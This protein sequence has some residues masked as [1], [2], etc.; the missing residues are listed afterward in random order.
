MLSPNSGIG[1]Y[2]ELETSLKKNIWHKKS[3]Y[4][5]S[6]RS[7]LVALLRSM[8]DVNLVWMPSYI[9]NS[10]FNAV[11]FAE[12]KIR[13]YHINESF[14]IIEKINLKKD[15]VLIFVNYFGI[16]NSS[17]NRTLESFDRN[18]IIID[19][20]Q[21]F[22]DPPYDCLAT[23]YSPRK[24][25]GIPDGGIIHTKIKINYD[26]EIDR[27][28]TSR[29]H[30]L[31]MRLDGRTNDGYEFYKESESSL[32]DPTP[33]KMSILTRKMI[34][35]IDYKSV[36]VK[37]KRNFDYLH[38]SLFDK[39]TLEIN[40]IEK[41]PLCYPLLPR[42]KIE[43]NDLIINNIYIPTYWPEIVH[44]DKLNNFELLLAENLIALPCSQQINYP[45]DLNK[46]I[47]NIKG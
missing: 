5:Q 43:K 2:P 47:Q 44:A 40:T 11:I 25:F 3:L 28:S 4:F 30:H 42:K 31:A 22:F 24:F 29:I 19:C 9:C 37:R 46:I 38:K 27:L 33:K 7:C 1:G 18:R 14:N 13:T 34:E 26:F 17:V 41:S 36:I 32:E 6:A 10:M 16:C 8:P 20:S 21:S 39:N 35:S 15:E 12:K 45:R 23:I